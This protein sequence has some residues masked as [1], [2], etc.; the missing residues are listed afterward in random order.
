[1]AKAAA[2]RSATH[3]QPPSSAAEIQLSGHC[4]LRYWASVQDCLHRDKAVDDLNGRCG[5]RLTA[6]QWYEVLDSALT[7]LTAPR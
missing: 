4:V 5:Q 2:P 3:S 6:Q 1:M 7:R